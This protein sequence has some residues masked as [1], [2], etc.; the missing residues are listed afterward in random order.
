MHYTREQFEKMAGDIS[1][2]TDEELD[3]KV[4]DLHAKVSAY[5]TD[6]YSDLDVIGGDK[7]SDH[8]KSLYALM[9]ASWLSG[10]FASQTKSS[11]QLLEEP[12]DAYL[13][14]MKLA[15]DPVGVLKDAWRNY[16][17]KPGFAE[18][19]KKFAARVD[20]RAREATAKP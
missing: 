1:Q 2:K 12:S 8:E 5:V 15:F 9:R 3:R 19:F 20:G 16:T 4:S 13:S 6:L 10:Y 14:A 7:A 11:T 18:E 17:S